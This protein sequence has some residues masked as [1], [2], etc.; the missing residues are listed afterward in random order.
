MLRVNSNPMAQAAG[1]DVGRAGRF[2]RDAMRK[3]SSGLRITRGA[4]DAA[5]LAVSENLDARGASQ[6]V[7]LR[8]ANDG[9]SII[10]TME[11]GVQEVGSMLKR[12]REL[13]VQSS[14]ETLANTERA[15]LNDEFKQLQAEIGRVRETSAFNGTNLLDGSWLSGKDVQVGA[16]DSV[17]DRIKIVMG[18]ISQTAS[19]ASTASYTGGP[20]GASAVVSNRQFYLGAVGSVAG[21]TALSYDRTNVTSDGVS[22]GSV[23][24]GSAIARANAINSDTG[25]HGVTATV[26]TT[27]Y[28]AGGRISGGTFNSGERLW[29]MGGTGSSLNLSVAGLTVVTN[30]TDSVFQDH[31]Q[32]ELDTRYGTGT[33]SVDTSSGALS[34]SAS[35]GRS[36]GFNIT[37][38]GGLSGAAVG[39]NNW[40]TGTLT[41]TSASDFEYGSQ[42]SGTATDWGVSSGTNVIA[43]TGGSSSVDLS[44]NSRLNISSVAGAQAALAIVDGGLSTV[45]AHRSKLGAV[46]NRLGSA[47]LNL[48]NNNEAVFAASSRI[49]DADFAF[50]SASLSKAQIMQSASTSVLAQVQQL[51]QSALR[52]IG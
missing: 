16:D 2:V 3:L 12:M 46:Q 30:D 13:A 7:A 24:G 43:A 42:T 6:R 19:V 35:D 5:G 47:M 26:N 15:Y 44:D 48:Q 18:D 38:A 4:D 1:R 36:F 20:V 31:I 45:N 14:S 41:L 34:I 32:A 37:D 50:E 39:T 11:G 49:R 33:Y 10:Q 17:N 28:T 23:D 22:S 52:L 21:G 25:S 29:F 9:I 40:A 51:P 8:N 27:T